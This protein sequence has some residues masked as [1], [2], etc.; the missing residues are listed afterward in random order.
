M[1]TSAC[2]HSGLC[3]CN[4]IKA[5]QID[6]CPRGMEKTANAFPEVISWKQ[7]FVFATVLGFSECYPGETK[8][9]VSHTHTTLGTHTTI[10]NAYHNGNAYQDINVY[11]EAPTYTTRGYVYQEPSLGIPWEVF[12]FFF[13]LFWSEMWWAWNMGRMELPPEPCEKTH[14]IVFRD[15]SPGQP[16][17]AKKKKKKVVW[18]RYVLSPDYVEDW[19]CAFPSPI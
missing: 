4:A 9:I 6:T 17:K 16:C 13:W 15:F 2:L 3:R 14:T 19:Q 10:G 5:H 11:H 18:S 12:F 7:A 1:H 8:P